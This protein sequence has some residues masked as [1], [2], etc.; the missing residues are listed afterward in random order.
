MEFDRRFTNK[1]IA[2]WG[3]LGLMKRLPDHLGFDAALAAAGLPQPG[4][5]RGYRPAQR[6]TQFM[7]SVWC[8]A[9][10]FEHGDVNASV[11]PIA[12]EAML[13]RR[14]LMLGF[15]FLNAR[16]A[17]KATVSQ[18]MARIRQKLAETSIKPYTLHTMKPS[19]AL[20]AHR[21]EIREIVRT[22]RAINPRVFGSVIHDTDT[23]TSDLDILI[24]P[25]PKTSRMDVAKI[26]V[27]LEAIL[28]VK[29]DVLNPNALPD[30]LRHIVLAEAVPV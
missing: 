17:G 14:P 27:E 22:H 19:V 12:P 13:I 1:E 29:V 3:G 18:P 7:L 10:R 4:S 15:S 20:N 24:D 30:S 16:R 28:G 23:D 2:G 21:A 25:T 6:I 8:G 5:N 9:N 11:L 26:Q